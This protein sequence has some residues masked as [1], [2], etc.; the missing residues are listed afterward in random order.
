MNASQGQRDSVPEGAVLAWII[1]DP[2]TLEQ[3]VRCASRE[4][5][6]AL[7]ANIGALICKLV[8]TH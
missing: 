1:V 8:K 4:E 7:N 6:R 3:C 5:A 2:D